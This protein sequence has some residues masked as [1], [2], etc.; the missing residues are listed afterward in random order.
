MFQDPN[1]QQEEIIQICHCFAPYMC[2]ST[3]EHTVRL[4]IQNTDLLPNLRLAIFSANFLYQFFCEASPR[5]QGGEI[6]KKWN[7]KNILKDPPIQS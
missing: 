1:I 7:L 3:S 6:S 4:A 2:P 5:K